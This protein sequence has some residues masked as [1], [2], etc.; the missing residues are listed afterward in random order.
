MP[1][2]AEPLAYTPA[3]FMSS[4]STP[5]SKAPNGHAD[6]TH[7]C[8]GRLADETSGSAVGGVDFEP[9]R[10][11]A[12]HAPTK[13]LFANPLSCEAEIRRMLADGDSLVC[14]SGTLAEELFAST[15]LNWMAPGSER[16][17]VFCDTFADAATSAGRLLVRPHARHLL[18][19]IPSCLA[20]LDRAEGTGLGLAFDPAAMCDH[21]MLPVVEDHFVRM[22]EALA[23]RSAVLLLGDL[24]PAKS[25]SIEG[26]AAGDAPPEIVPLG[27]GRLRAAFLRNLLESHL[28]T[29]TPVIFSAPDSE[30]QAQRD[31]LGM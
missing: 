6:G 29:G 8:W 16:F 23:G 20:F 13:V 5:Q 25:G 27:A 14:W 30:I 31:W 3:A 7:R 9:S 1:T 28:P 21:S 10:R 24:K 15:P 17:R 18:S 22:F 12:D 2:S 4:P 19:D 11:P 26:D